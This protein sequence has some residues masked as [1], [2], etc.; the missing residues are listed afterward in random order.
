MSLAR[1]TP[2]SASLYTNPSRPAS[3]FDDVSFDD[4]GPGFDYSQVL[5]YPRGSEFDFTS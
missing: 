4:E 1:S 3:P 5:T 2:R